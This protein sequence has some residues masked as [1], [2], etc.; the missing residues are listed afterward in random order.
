ML[1]CFWIREA[2]Y[3]DDVSCL[4]VCL[5]VCPRAYLLNCTSDLYMIFLCMLP[6]SVA[7]SSSGGIA[8][9]YVMPVLWMT[10]YLYAMDQKSAGSKARVETD[11][12][13]RPVALPFPLTRLVNVSG[14]GGGGGSCQPVCSIPLLKENASSAACRQQRRY[15]TM[16]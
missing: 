7:R 15:C 11:G 8:L 9:R 5:S 13:T 6:I 16:R 14:S 3:Y 10:S 12:R 2:K 1:C 4:F